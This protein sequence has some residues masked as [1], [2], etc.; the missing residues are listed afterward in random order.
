MGKQR[1]YIHKLVNGCRP[2]GGVT[3]LP[4]I[5]KYGSFN[6]PC[7]AV[8]RIPSLAPKVPFLLRNPLFSIGDAYHVL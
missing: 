7:R 3:A 6:R 8:K 1:G 5:I 2:L 4:I